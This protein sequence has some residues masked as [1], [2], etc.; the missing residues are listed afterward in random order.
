MMQSLLSDKSK[1]KR[2]IRVFIKNNDNTP[3]Y[4]YMFVYD[5]IR[6]CEYGSKPK[7]VL[8]NMALI[9]Q[10]CIIRSCLCKIIQ[11][12]VYL[13]VARYLKVS[14]LTMVL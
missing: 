9:Q 7:F 5:Y 14:L 12:Y 8:K 6:I 3:I 4:V 11:I 10:T 1:M 13:F 2:R